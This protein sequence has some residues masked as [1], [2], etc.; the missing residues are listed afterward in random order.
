MLL[1]GCGYSCNKVKL[2]YTEYNYGDIIII[3][4]RY[5][6]AVNGRYGIVGFTK[7]GEEKKT[8]TFPTYFINENNKIDSIGIK[9]VYIG[10]NANFVKVA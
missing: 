7:E 5:S 2:T 4:N 3:K 6:P 8:I 1:S 10:K 9:H